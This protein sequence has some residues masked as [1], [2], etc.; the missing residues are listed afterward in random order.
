MSH[1]PATE[2][3]SSPQ[4][5]TPKLKTLCFVA[6]GAAVF[7]VVG[8][9]ASGPIRA[10][11]DRFHSSDAHA[12]GE[13]DHNGGEEN[14][15]TQW[16]ISGMHPWIIRP[17]PGY[18]PVC[19]MELTP[20]SPDML[21]GELS[22]DPLIVQNIGVRTAEVTEGPL[23]GALHTVGTVEFD[24]TT[25][26]EI[27]LRAPGYL[28]R[29]HLRYVGQTV[30]AGSV[31]AE[32]HSPAII[33]ALNEL[34]ALRRSGS[35]TAEVRATRQRLRV[36]GL[37]SEQ[38][39]ALEAADET[40]WTVE[41]KAASAGVVTRIN[42]TEG[43]WLAEGAA[44]VET[45]SLD[46]VW[47]IATVFESQLPRVRNG[48]KAI[49]RLTHLPG[50][51]LDG[52]VDFIFPTIDPVTRQ[53]RARLVFDNADHALKPGMFLRLEIDETTTE[54]VLQVPREAVLD[55]GQR[56]VAYVSLGDGRFEPR[57]VRLGRETER[58]QVEILEGLRRGE[59]VVVSGQFL[60]DS[61]ARLRESL[62][63]LVL[64][65]TA[66]EQKVQ[67]PVDARPDLE[68]LPSAFAS[69]LSAMLD[70]YL[71][72]A[73]PLID[74]HTDGMARA[75]RDLASAAESAARAA[76]DLPSDYRSEI[77]THAETIASAARRMAESTTPRGARLALRDLSDTLREILHR[78]GLPADYADEIHE[79]RCPMFPELGENA[80]WFQRATTT[81][82]PYMGQSMLTCHDRRFSLPRVGESPSEEA[83]E[84]ET[85][86]EQQH[87]HS[88]TNDNTVARGAIMSFDPVSLNQEEETALRNAI[89]A[90]LDLHA[91]L[92]RD[93]LENASRRGNELQQNLAA[94][95]GLERASAAAERLV[96]V[97][98]IDDARMPFAIIGEELIGF[99]HA[100]GLPEGYGPDDLIAARCHMFPNFDEYGWWFQRDEDLKNP[101]WGPAMLACADIVRPIMERDEGH[102]NGGHDHD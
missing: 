80:W 79:V 31:I 72:A 55:T 68:A 88:E 24:E 94:L 87:D 51:S 26:R 28:E 2:P 34:R 3:P 60:L 9:F 43:S 20:L 23:E 76:S 64:G 59:R 11:F 101:L 93:S 99:I 42:A 58:G 13:H 97:E 25:R 74:D 35:D 89:D 69:A 50:R 53:G 46:R 8:V 21:T 54:T 52:T 85:E 95:S 67:A 27:V 39:E 40:P 5:A 7:F 48:S 45:A 100:A 57:E 81:A 77:T 102:D 36:L 98:S 18:C 10:L 30:K 47:A 19:G 33:A 92:V 86:T 84:S 82:N 44:I 6:I 17:E 75:A 73:A 37:Q 38:I 62:L 22:I 63:K 49:A 90:Y 16:Y 32:I 41:L 1:N 96:A 65:D 4:A 61:E 12:T 56:Q 78:T 15:T 66:S 91:H 29:L 14:G 83:M 71:D 70:A